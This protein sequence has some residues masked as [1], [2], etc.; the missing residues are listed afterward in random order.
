MPL[1][2]WYRDH[3]EH[4]EIATAGTAELL[5]VGDSIT[6]GAKWSEVW[7]KTFGGYRFAN[8]GIGGDRT[9][10]VLWRLDHGAVGALKP[11]AVV[12]LI[13]TNNL[14]TTADDVADTERGIRAVVA[15][16]HASFPTARVLVLGV[17]PRDA[18]ADAPVR[19]KVQRLNA[20]LASLDDGKTT[21]VRDIG[22]V[23][24]E[25]DGSLSAAVAPD[26]LH[27]SEEGYRRWAEAIA[28]TVAEMM[29]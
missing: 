25:P 6:A 15:R 8:F 19:A 4:V 10:N 27:L 14:W 13:G 2:T 3:A 20:A 12:L 26:Q 1:A 7:K 22:G 24:L 29:R 11:K 17:F 23:F 21:L 9:Q 28:P 5:F 18:K 16:L